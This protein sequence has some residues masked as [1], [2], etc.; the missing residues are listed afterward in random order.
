MN[1]K[2]QALQ[3]EVRALGQSAVYKNGVE[4]AK[5]EWTTQ[6]TRELFLFLVDRT[7]LP[8]NDIVNLFWGDKSSA[9]GVRQFSSNTLS[10]EASVWDGRCN[11]RKSRI[12]S[13]A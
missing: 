5:A 7:T 10:P 4:I 8:R 3:V 13:L 12:S 2:T 6:K 1:E 9:Q 11:F